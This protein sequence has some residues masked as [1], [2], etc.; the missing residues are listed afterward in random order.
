MDHDTKKYAA[1][2]FHG[3]ATIFETMKSPGPVDCCI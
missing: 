1:L 3:H 2:L